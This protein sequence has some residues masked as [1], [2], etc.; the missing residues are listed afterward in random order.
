MIQEKMNVLE[1]VGLSEANLS[2]TA[3]N[4]S[5]HSKVNCVFVCKLIMYSVVKSFYIYI[6]VLKHTDYFCLSRIL[7]RGASWRCSRDHSLQM[8][9]WM[10]PSCWRPQMTGR[11]LRPKPRLLS[12]TAPVRASSG[13][14]KTDDWPILLPSFFGF[15]HGAK[16]SPTSQLHH[17]CTEL[18]VILMGE[19]YNKSFCFANTEKCEDFF[20]P[21]FWHPLSCMVARLHV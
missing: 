16:P 14:T 8:T 4:T 10:R 2:E 13:A 1:Q 19:N 6:Y 3:E 20:L 15:A 9:T 11:T 7:P 12:T 17:A 18:K 5:F 21:S